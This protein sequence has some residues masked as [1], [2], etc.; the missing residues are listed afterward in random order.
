LIA[1]QLRIM[2]QNASGNITPRKASGIKPEF[3]LASAMQMN[4]IKAKHKIP[5]KTQY[6]SSSRSNR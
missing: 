6:P 1:K 4:A 5:D 2:L 3:T